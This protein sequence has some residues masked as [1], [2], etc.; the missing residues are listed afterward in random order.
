MAEIIRF[1]S[2][3][4]EQ[5]SSIDTGNAHVAWRDFRLL[6]NLARARRALNIRLI[7]EALP[8]GC[9]CRMTA[10]PGNEPRKGYQLRAQPT[11]TA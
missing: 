1:L 11:R 5:R 3:S 10:N 8:A 4:F 9:C 6:H 2:I 7:D